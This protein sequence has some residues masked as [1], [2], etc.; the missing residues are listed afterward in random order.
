MLETFERSVALGV[1]LLRV[2]V[3]DAP[4]VLPAL[5]PEGGWVLC[6]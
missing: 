6:R 4:A 5:G 2:V 1:E 3:G